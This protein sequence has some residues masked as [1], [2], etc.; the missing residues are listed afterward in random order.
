MPRAD[1]GRSPYCASRHLLRHLDDARELCR[2][3]LVRGMFPPERGGRDGEQRRAIDRVRRRVTVSLAGMRDHARSVRNVQLGRAH[4]ALLRCE[5]DAQPL[6]VVA[7]EL[8]LSERQMRRE[9]QAAHVLFLRAFRTGAAHETRRAIVAPDTAA[10]RVAEGVELHELGESDLAARVL[11][12]VETAAASAERRV[13]AAC[14]GAEIDLERG[15]I[16]A[17]KD[18]LVKARALLDARGDELDERAG[19]VA[20]QHLELAEWT[21]RWRT[22]QCAGIA[23]RPPAVVAHADAVHAF[24]G[25]R[26]RALLARA[27]AVYADQRWECGD[28][29]AMTAA[30]KRAA[31]LLRTLDPARAKERLAVALAEARA[32]GLGTWPGGDAAAFAAVERRAAAAGHVRT[33]LRARSERIGS[34]LHTA[35]HL[36]AQPDGIVTAFGPRE[37]REMP[38]A[39]AGAARILAQSQPLE[40]VAD[41][42]ELTAAYAPARSANA[43]LARCARVRSVLALG[44]HDDAAALA[45]DVLADAELAGNPRV[46]GSAHRYLAQIAAA[47]GARH[48]AV[49]HVGEA[50]TL[51]ERFGT[52]FAHREA[53]RLGRKLGVN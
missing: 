42:A 50:L 26:H 52:P 37:R 53:K 7:A 10:V 51:L 43:L 33:A 3:P 25:E 34:E 31:E 29:A 40:R 35:P 11:L 47:R 45:Q 20:R 4:A 39:F 17:A 23:A 8:G 48:E 30:L 28:A 6:A 22:D 2:N 12:E 24:G 36:P 46:R 15:R 19:A 9:R 18:R 1:P 32:L 27:L 5:I 16:D 14:A 41:A 13:E 21:L 38:H 44:A 49:R